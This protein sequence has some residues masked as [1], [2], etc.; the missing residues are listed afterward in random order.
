MGININDDYFAK[1]TT[2]AQKKKYRYLGGE[3][4]LPGQPAP[5]FTLANL[6]DERA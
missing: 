2:F 6:R 5:K 1:L 4:P 3:R